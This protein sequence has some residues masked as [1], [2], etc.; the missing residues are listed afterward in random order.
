MSSC[1]LNFADVFWPYPHDGS[2][3]AFPV[4]GNSDQQ[5]LCCPLGGAWHLCPW[6]WRWRRLSNLEKIYGKVYISPTL[7]HLYTTWPFAQPYPLCRVCQVHAKGLQFMA[8][9][10]RWWLLTDFY[11]LHQQG[12]LQY[13]LKANQPTQ[14]RMGRWGTLTSKYTRLPPPSSFLSSLISVLFSPKELIWI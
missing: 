13:W 6:G 11:N 9:V 8:C 12:A 10:Q 5:E 2:G 4:C 14:G 7:C 1:H 3:G